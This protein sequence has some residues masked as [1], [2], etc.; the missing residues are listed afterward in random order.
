[1]ITFTSTVKIPDYN[2]Q[3]MAHMDFEFKVGRLSFQ[4]WR[5]YKYCL[6]GKKSCKKY[7]K[8]EKFSVNK[9]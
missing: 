4:I 6:C 5:T 8:W 9:E 3:R 1:M 7:K 2:H